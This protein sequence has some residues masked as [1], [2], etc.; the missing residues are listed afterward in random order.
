M[1]EVFGPFTTI[2]LARDCA[3]KNPSSLGSG[4]GRWGE[5]PAYINAFYAVHPAGPMVDGPYLTVRSA[6]GERK[7]NVRDKEG[8]SIDCQR[9][10]GFVA[11]VVELFGGTA[12]FKRLP[13]CS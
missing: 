12:I 1:R 7:A 9:D 8:F 2:E 6:E 4:N 11:V 5:A 13:Q 10:R 3:K